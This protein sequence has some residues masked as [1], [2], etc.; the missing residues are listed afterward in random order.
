VT[1]GL[2]TRLPFKLF[3]RQRELIRFFQACLD[4]EASGIV[5]KSRD[6]GATWCACAFAV[7]VWLFRPGASVGFGSRVAPL[8]DS[9]GDPDSIFEKIRMLV[10]ALPPEFR[11]AEYDASYMKMLNRDNGSSITG[12]S[13]DE[14]RPPDYAS[15]LRWRIE[16]LEGFRGLGGDKLRSGAYAFYGGDSSTDPPRPP[17]PAT[18]IEDWV[19]TVDPRNA[20]RGLLTRMPFKLFRRQRDLIRFFKACLDAEANG[21]VEKSRDMGATWWACSFAVWLWL[22]R[23]GASI[24]FG[25]RKAQLVDRIGDLDS[26]FEKLRLLLRALPPEFRP[27][28]YDAAYMKLVNN[29][30]GAMITGE[31]GDEIGRG[32]RKLIYF[33]DEASHLEHP[34]S[35]EAALSENTRVRIDISSVNGLG[36]VFHRRREAAEEWEPNTKMRRDGTYAFVLDWRDHPEKTEEWYRERRQ[37]FVDEG[38]LHIFRQE[39][40]GDYAAS[41]ANSIIPLEWIRSAIDAHIKFP[42]MEEGGW[43]AGLD[44]ADG[45]GDRNALATRRGVVL[46][47]VDEWGERDTG[48]TARRAVDACRRVGPIEVQYDCIGVGAGVKAEIN[49]LR[50]EQ[51]VPDDI[52]FVP[53]DAGAS[54][55]HPKRRVIPGDHASPLNKDFYGNL[56]AQAWW[57]LRRRFEL[58]HRAVTEG[59]KVEPDEMVSISSEIPKV[60]AL[61]KELAQPTSTLPGRMRLIVEKTPE[62]SSS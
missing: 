40:D 9:I 6:M 62:G 61:E 32:G 11:P 48:A 28:S 51:L 34:E 39:V 54:P 22:F 60:R 41:V 5:E 21:L 29:D 18:F 59:I 23:P 4:N 38:L 25:S 14:I 43:C 19:D 46:R 45:G 56:K 36:N 8:V 1:R 24:G 50:D 17:H 37:K 12:E 53:W 42:G 30:S 10:R 27:A 58:T 26:I 20:T 57:S 15:H 2:L 33:V 52:R 3:K 13:G 44:V 35:I 55:L 47:H 16:T 7:W 49:R 31:S